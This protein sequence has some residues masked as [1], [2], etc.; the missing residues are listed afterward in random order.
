MPER[1]PRPVQIGLFEVP[2]LY[3]RPEPLIRRIRRALRRRRTEPVP[4]LSCLLCGRPASVCIP[5][6]QEDAPPLGE[7]HEFA[8]E[9][10]N[11]A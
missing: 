7:E 3:A 6:C 5:L 8:Q 9:L 1:G 11:S 10:A 4:R 2:P